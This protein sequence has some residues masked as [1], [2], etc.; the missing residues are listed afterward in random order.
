MVNNIEGVIRNLKYESSYNGYEVGFPNNEVVS[1]YKNDELGVYIYVDDLTYDI[2]E[3]YS[4][5][6]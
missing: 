4:E 5:N 1:F 2:L 6:D 3:I